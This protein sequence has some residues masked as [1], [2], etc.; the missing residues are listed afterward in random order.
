MTSDELQKQLS[1]TWHRDQSA[2]DAHDAIWGEPFDGE[3]VRISGIPTGETKSDLPPVLG[4]CCGPPCCVSLLDAETAP[5]DGTMI[6][7]NFGWPWLVPAAWSRMSATWN[8]A[9]YNAS[10]EAVTSTEVHD[11]WWE[12][13]TEDNRD[14]KGWMPIPPIP[15]NVKVHTPLPATANDETEVKP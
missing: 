15:H 3:T 5:H 6:L 12:F 13:E 14:L 1:E 11:C 10:A 8:V 2:D 4:V 7:A 9:V